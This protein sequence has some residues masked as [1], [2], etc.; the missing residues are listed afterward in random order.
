MV[1]L[2]VFAVSA[3]D[4]AWD[5]PDVKKNQGE[6]LLTHCLLK[7]VDPL[8]VVRLYR[9]VGETEYSI[10]D[11]GL[12][13]PA[14]AATGRYSVQYH[15]YNMIASITL[16]ITGMDESVFFLFIHFRFIFI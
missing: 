13:K 2:F 15:Y 3:G 10:S 7:G 11:N 12:L 5:S 16:V 4:P 14:Y 9:T 6:T 8:R 1:C